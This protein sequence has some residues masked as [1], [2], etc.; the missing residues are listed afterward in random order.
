MSATESQVTELLKIRYAPPTWAFLSQ[1]ADATGARRGGWADAVAMGLWPSRGMELHGFEIKVSRS[2]W[3]RELKNPEK[4]DRFVSYCDRWW[5]VA[6]D[7]EI[8]RPGELPPTWGLIVLRGEKTLRVETEAP[9]LTPVP[10]DRWLVAAIFRRV[11]EQIVPD[12]L[13]KAEFERGKNEQEQRDKEMRD[14]EL[15]DAKKAVE[16]V[17]QRIQEFESAS[18]FRI[19]GY[20][21][22]PSETARRIGQIVTAVLNE[23]RDDG[24]S[25]F[26][27]QLERVLD[28]AERIVKDVKERIEAFK[29]IEAKM[30]DGK[31]SQRDQQ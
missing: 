24:W 6:G 29:E 17:E 5:I 1:V 22:I 9:K 25:S 12:A 30:A 18:G 8:V 31:T 26:G 23:E 21:A 10:I 16:E 7:S 2:D 14:D 19:S 20:G 13:L 3:I 11:T 27:R 4:A 28:S 15:A